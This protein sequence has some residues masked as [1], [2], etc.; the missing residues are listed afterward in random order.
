M[1]MTKYTLWTLAALLAGCVPLT[2][3]SPPVEAITGQTTQ[4]IAPDAA[5][6][7]NPPIYRVGDRW[8]YS[9]GYGAEVTEITAD[10]LSTFKR[11]DK[12]G[13]W[14]KRRGLFKMESLIG[15]KKRV[16]VY[17]TRSPENDIYPLAV[18]KKSEFDREYLINDK[19]LMVHRST[20]RVVGRQTIE[21]PAGKFD[22]W[23]IE[24]EDWSLK[25]NWLG[26]EKWFYSPQARNFIRMEYQYGQA[27]RGSRVL[28]R[29][30][31]AS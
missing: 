23:V 2:P 5:L 30:H 9:D 28:V 25:S 22:C 26:I 27:P 8:E 15:S 3:T 31:L 20:W 14:F 29:Y 18:G 7:P 12:I 11:L 6:D 24:V 13:D 16:E 4:A 1:R 17:R 19:D 10:G 21:V